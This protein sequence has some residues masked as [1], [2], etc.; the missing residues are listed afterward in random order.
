MMKIRSILAVLLL[1][2]S[3]AFAQ[4]A[5]YQLTP[6]KPGKSTLLQQEMFPLDKTG[7]FR[8]EYKVRFSDN[9]NKTYVFRLF[10]KEQTTKP[11]KQVRVRQFSLNL[12]LKGG[13]SWSAPVKGKFTGVIGLRYQLD[14]DLEKVEAGKW[15]DFA[16]E[17]RKGSFTAY[18]YLDGVEKRLC[19][20]NLEQDWIRAGWN[21]SAATALTVSGV[22]L[23]DVAARPAPATPA[24]FT[25]VP[26][27][28]PMVK[29][30]PFPEKGCSFTFISG[31]FPSKIVINMGAGKNPPYLEFTSFAHDFVRKERK[32]VTEKVNGKD[33]KKRIDVTDAFQFTDAGFRMRLHRD[34]VHPSRP[35]PLELFTRTRIAG[36]F[37]PAQMTEILKD[38]SK[39]GTPASVTP[40]RCDFIPAGDGTLQV[41]LNHNFY[42]LYPEVPAELVVSLPA[43]AAYQFGEAEKRFVPVRRDLQ[44][45]VAPP[46][47]DAP[48]TEKVIDG[49]LL[50]Y[51]DAEHAFPVALCKENL[52][53]Y[54]L[55]CDGYLSRTAFDA[56]PDC[57]LKRIPVAQYHRAAVVCSLAPDPENKMTTDVT[58]RLTSFYSRHNAGQ[59]PDMILHKTVTL[60]RDPA[61]PLPENVKKIGDNLFLIYYDFDIGSIQDLVFMCGFNGLDFEVMGGLH[62]GDNYYVSRADKP[63]SNPSAVRV[64]GAT[65]LK[66]PAT[67]MVKSAVPGNLYYPDEQP[68]MSAHVKALNAGNYTVEWQV[69][70]VDQKVVQT[71][72]DVLKLS[73]G[74]E[75][76][77]KVEFTAKE[78]GHYTVRTTLLD[79]NGK[80]LVNVPGAFVRLAPDTRKAGLKSPYLSW[81]FCGSHGTVSDLEIIC[82]TLKRA[83]VRRTQL[84]NDK[85]SEEDMKKYNLT[86]TPFQYKHIV[87]PESITDP[88]E[89]AAAL[90]KNI[91]YY[92][93]RYPSVDV[94]M[95][96]HETSGGPHP[97]EFIGEKTEITPEQKLADEKKAAQAIEVARAWRRNAP[98]VR[99]IVGNSGARLGVM[100]MLFR[101]GYPR[102]LI[103]VIGEESVGQTVTPER[104]TAGAFYNLW[105]LGRIY[106]YKDL[107]VEASYEWKNRKMPG[108][109]TRERAS[110]RIRDALIAHAWNSKTIPVPTGSKYRNGYYN[111]VWGGG[112]FSRWPLYQP[113][114]EFCATAVMTQVLDCVEFQRLVPTGS[115]TAYASEFKRGGEYVYAFW[116]ARGSTGFTFK[117]DSTKMTR[118]DIYGRSRT[119]P[120]A[121]DGTY[122]D[123]ISTEPFY[124]VTDKQITDIKVNEQRTYPWEVP[125]PENPTVACA[126]DDAEKWTQDPEPD[127][128]M[129]VPE[130]HQYQRHGKFSVKTVEDEL[131][132]KCM[133]VELIP[134]GELNRNLTE[135]TFLRLKEPVPVNGSPDTI[136]VWVKGNSSWGKLYFEI[137]D[138]DGQVFM[139]GGRATY[140]DW[141]DRLGINF[142]GWHFLSFPLTSKSPVKVTCPGENE[143]QWKSWTHIPNKKKDFDKGITFPIKV[144]AIAV[145]IPR[146]TLYI[147][148]KVETPVKSIRLKDFSVY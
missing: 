125:Y 96:F 50:R 72:K 95:I 121:K 126:M 108:F 81:N 56:M 104:S 92:V 24:G 46:S 73:A 5:E 1:V 30:F 107:G 18:L 8:L 7:D 135:Y 113:S 110:W 143:R 17:R 99:L 86:R 69:T 67:F 38:P 139:S 74:E 23:K 89:R 52:G 79:Q 35:L 26:Q 58:A 48:L 63:A 117:T 130:S 4:S 118:T 136:G 31:S 49:I 138:S 43:G 36:R 80:Q 62:R 145:E 129:L 140:Y 64:H 85:Y 65:L 124:L 9:A 32:W 78:L 19:A 2:F 57:Y 25:Q 111:T 6:E 20:M 21:L 77:I 84:W 12:N 105:E 82:N 71:K 87:I 120:E 146:H 33:V 144:R 60:P 39:Y 123:T 15:Y 14:K 132:G 54:M 119:I 27:N 83:G 103:D 44:Q 133:E 37:K 128:R 122:Q 90:D 93:K 40:V 22:A 29:N 75:K 148:D 100:A 94:A 41:W 34:I 59:A 88:A 141:P 3:A 10:M 55:E 45:V 97:L 42:A 102:D 47:P 101:A 61:A 13:S 11:V 91:Q 127:P 68:W 51:N 131:K 134:E 109:T 66:T 98:H 106:G 142:D 76:E 116:L 137:E 16:V 114:S 53:M 70:D 112:V 147:K 28:E 115:M